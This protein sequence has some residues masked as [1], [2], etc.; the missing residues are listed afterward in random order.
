MAWKTRSGPVPL[1]ALP[2]DRAWASILRAS[3][4][5]AFAAP[6]R[7]VPIRHV[8]ACID[9]LQMVAPAPKSQYGTFPG[10]FAE[11]AI[12]QLNLMLRI[13]IIKNLWQY[14]NKI[15]VSR[16]NPRYNPQ[17]GRTGQIGF[18]KLIALSVKAQGHPL[19]SQY[20]YQCKGL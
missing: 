7:H 18:S 5:G 2:Q 9:R 14:R 19:S 17:S 3:P 15:T 11:K 4:G 13:D 20:G 8:G 6:I 16:S 10:F 12:A 1:V